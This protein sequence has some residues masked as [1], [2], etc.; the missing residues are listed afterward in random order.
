MQRFAFVP[1]IQLMSELDL[2]RARDAHL[3]T[4]R[5]D[6]VPSKHAIL[7][8]LAAFVDDRQPVPLGKS[9]CERVFYVQDFTVKPRDFHSWAPPR[10]LIYQKQRADYISRFYD[11][12]PTATYADLLDC[13]KAKLALYRQQTQQWVALVQDQ[14]R[15]LEVAYGKPHPRDLDGVISPSLRSIYDVELERRMA[16]DAMPAITATTTTAASTAAVSSGCVGCKTSEYM[17]D[18]IEYGQVC[19]N[20][21]VVAE[22]A[23]TIDETS[24]SLPFGTQMT[25]SNN[26]G[27]YEMTENFMKNLDLLEGT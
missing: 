6:I 22:N 25:L 24:D 13:E 18:T 8:E 11:A 26:R 7:A 1:K 21:G 27:C 9:L 10:K 5:S 3:R 14:S 2:H 12:L 19:A 23:S 16:V 15:D 20:C 17:I 4:L